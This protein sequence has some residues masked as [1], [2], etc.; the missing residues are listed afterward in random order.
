MTI[1]RALYIKSMFVDSN[2]VQTTQTAASIETWK[3]LGDKYLIVLVKHIF[4]EE[5]RY[6]QS[7]IYLLLWFS[8]L[9]YLHEWITIECVTLKAKERHLSQFSVINLMFKII[10][11]Y[12]Q[13]L[14]PIPISF[15][16]HLQSELWPNNYMRLLNWFFDWIMVLK[17]L[18]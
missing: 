10:C 1:F 16:L 18:L 12:P 9:L 5:M 2:T 15:S 13:N 4:L 7:K 3:L 6:S 8:C 14:F 11:S 17:L